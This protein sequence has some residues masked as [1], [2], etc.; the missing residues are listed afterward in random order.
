MQDKTGVIL[1]IAGVGLGAGLMFFLDPSRGKQ[2]RAAV[3]D[4]AK[5]TSRKIERAAKSVDRSAHDL[6]EGT[7]ELAQ[8]VFL[9]KKKALRLV[10]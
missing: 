1:G 2:R 10:A 4:Q 5:R 9:W 7:N 6:V 8:R 3:R